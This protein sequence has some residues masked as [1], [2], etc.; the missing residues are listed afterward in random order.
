MLCNFRACCAI[1]LSCC[2]IVWSCCVIS[3]S[4]CVLSRLAPKNTKTYTWTRADVHPVGGVLCNFSCLLCNCFQMFV[5]VA[6]VPP[7]TPFEEHHCGN[8]KP[9]A[10]TAETEGCILVVCNIAALPVTKPVITYEY[11]WLSVIICEYLCES[12]RICKKF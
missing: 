1:V 4:C 2:V 8:S 12:V 9:C 10:R 7:T 5:C 11:L 3:K 6:R